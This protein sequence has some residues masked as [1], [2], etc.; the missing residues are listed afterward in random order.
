MI[1]FNA[2][3]ATN[4]M[5]APLLNQPHVDGHAQRQNVLDDP[6]QFSLL[7]PVLK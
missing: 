6:V 2:G 5:V 3:I 7:A 4:F 1:S